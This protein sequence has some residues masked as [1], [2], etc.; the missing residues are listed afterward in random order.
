MCTWGIVSEAV[1]FE[2][3]KQKTSVV[4]YISEIAFLFI[5]C[6]MELNIYSTNIKVILMLIFLE[7]CPQE[8]SIVF[9]QDCWAWTHIF[10]G[11]L[12]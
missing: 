9:S 8:Y 11:N 6:W 1:D 3:Y 7:F 5:E 4:H 10:L 12:S 2:F